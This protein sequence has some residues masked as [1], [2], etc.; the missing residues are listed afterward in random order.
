MPTIDH[1]ETLR[2][3]TLV[4]NDTR[5]AHNIVGD[6]PEA[7]TRINLDSIRRI[8]LRNLCSAQ[9][10]ASAALMLPDINLRDDLAPDLY[11]A[12]EMVQR[13][14]QHITEINSDSLVGAITP[15]VAADA[16]GVMLADVYWQLQATP[17]QTNVLKSRQKPTILDSMLRLLLQDK[18]HPLKLGDSGLNLLD[19]NRISTFETDL[20]DRELFPESTYLTR[21][22]ESSDAPVNEFP[23]MA[24]SAPNSLSIDTLAFKCIQPNERTQDE[25]FWLTWFYEIGNLTDVYDEIERAVK[26]DALVGTNLDINWKTRH[27]LSPIFGNIDEGKEQTM[28]QNVGTVAAYKGFCPWHLEVMCIE[29]DDQEYEAISEVLETIENT[30]ATIQGVA[31]GIAAVGGPTVITAGAAA[32]AAAARIAQTAAA[33]ADAVVDIVN[34]F[35]SD[36]TI[37]IN[38][39]NGEADL[40][41]VKPGLQLTDEIRFGEMTRNRGRYNL[42]IRERTSMQVDKFQRN[43]RVW[44]LK[45]TAGTF[46]KRGYG[47]GASGDERV[48]IRF[49]EPME[50]I[51]ASGVTC[52]YKK[53]V[54]HAEWKN[55]PKLAANGRSASG[56]VHWGVSR[57][58]QIAFTPWVT[59]WKI[60]S[61]NCDENV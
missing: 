48:I 54:R 26:D 42:S 20:F 39:L 3:G 57:F 56:T 40:C 6:L 60:V 17:R 52:N 33:V 7:N 50:R 8:R 59:A 41:C 2:N 22:Q 32:V 24:A 46:R 16:P 28:P 61:S 13:G 58:N 36:D 45:R 35:D 37:G 14:L 15:Y 18:A 5:S 1:A 51:V 38:G 25:I 44:Q 27:W 30:A 9:I 53:G 49:P 47:V 12:R 55:Q 4:P 29:N 11:K 19:P 31:A 23:A 34:F 43:W 10:L 21:A